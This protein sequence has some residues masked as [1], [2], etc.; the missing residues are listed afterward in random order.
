MATSSASAVTTVAAAHELMKLSYRHIVLRSMPSP[1]SGQSEQRCYAA[2]SARAPMIWGFR[3]VWLVGFPG[4]T[5]WVS[6]R[7]DV[8]CVTSLL[9][10][11]NSCLPA[12]AVGAGDASPR[13]V[14]SIG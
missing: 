8:L 3:L 14:L 7:P 11:L 5:L 6:R 1:L 9:F 12:A 2:C 4:L 13:V 10:E